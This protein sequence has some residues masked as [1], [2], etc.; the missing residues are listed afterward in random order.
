MVYL[1]RGCKLIWLILLFLFIPSM[2]FAVTASTRSYEELGL[3]SA[4]RLAIGS[5]SISH[6]YLGIGWT[7]TLQYQPNDIIVSTTFDGTVDAGSDANTIIDAAL[8]QANDYWNFARV[9]ILT[10][11][12]NLA[13]KGETSVITDFI[14]AS[15]ELAFT[16]LTDTVDVGDTYRVEFGILIDRI[17]AEDGIITWGIIDDDITIAYGESSSGGDDLTA[18]VDW[19]DMPEAGLSSTWYANGE[20]VASLPGYDNFNEIATQ[21]G[22]PTFIFYFW[23]IIG[24]AFGVFLLLA[25]FT[26]SALL[27]VVGFNVVLFIGSSMTVVAMWLPFAILVTQIGIL[28][29]YKQV[30]Y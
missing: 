28:Y 9:T 18:S 22:M 5:T 2:I 20:N 25:M 13:P 3:S 12:D 17:G 7:D 23:F 14:D 8:T 10:T 21:M 15:D 4:G 16:A 26:R 29:L 24:L 6:L 27:G 30:S 11:T 1:K 19:W